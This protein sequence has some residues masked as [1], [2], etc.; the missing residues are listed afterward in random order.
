MLQIYVTKYT[1]S[2]SATRST[3]LLEIIH[4]DICEPFDTPSFGVEKYFITFI[5]DFSR[6]EYVYLLNKKSQAVNSLEVFIKEVERQLDR[7]VKIVK[8]D[9]GGEYY[10]KHGESRQNPGPFA[11]FLERHDICAQ[12]TMPDTP[13]QN[14]M[15]KR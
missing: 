14:G 3:Q 5:D 2:C 8:S 10:E 12:Y 11:Q 15:T 1:F 13:Q 7:K 4:A 9:R 6:Y